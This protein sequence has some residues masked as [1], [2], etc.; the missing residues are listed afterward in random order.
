MVRGD[1]VIADPLAITVS[2]RIEPRDYFGTVSGGRC[3]LHDPARSDI[4]VSDIA[5]ALSHVCR[6]GG[7]IETH[8]SVAQ[9]S[10]L[11]SHLV[12]PGFELAALIHDAT[13]AYLGDVISPLKRILGETY[14]ALERRWE[15]EIFARFGIARQ[16]AWRSGV[17]GLP[18]EVKAADHRAFEIE[19]WDLLLPDVRRR[20]IGGTGRPRGPAIMPIESKL[21]AQAWLRRYWE[22]T[23]KESGE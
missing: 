7:Q 5:I 23:S 2:E 17:R 11:V 10:V 13:E 9:H 20:A 19:C 4:R 15:G 21:A 6:F 14:A 8:Y 3:Y 1:V 12:A 22:L 16:L 18:L